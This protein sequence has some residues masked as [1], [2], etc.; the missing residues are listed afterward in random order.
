MN[1]KFWLLYFWA[2]SSKKSRLKQSCGTVRNSALDWNRSPIHGF[3]HKWKPMFSA[4]L[5]KRQHIDQCVSNSRTAIA[6]LVG[7][8][9]SVTHTETY[10]CATVQIGFGKNR[11]SV[12]STGIKVYVKFLFACL[13][14]VSERISMGMCGPCITYRGEKMCIQGFG[15][16]I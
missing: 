4:L 12:D 9:T 3:T 13:Y 7:H 16:V 1:F 8:L 11:G 5:I 14:F 2:D 10:V 6:C 15:G